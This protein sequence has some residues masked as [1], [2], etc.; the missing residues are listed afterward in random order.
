MQAYLVSDGQR[1][2]D[3]SVFNKTLLTHHRF[4]HDVGSKSLDLE[5]PLRI[6]VMEPVERGGGQEMDRRAVEKYPRGKG[7]VGDGAPVVEAFDIRPV[8]FSMRRLRAARGPSPGRYA[9]P[10]PSWI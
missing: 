9:T 4:H 7:E 3:P 8:L 10:L 2:T 1:V 6:E 5:P